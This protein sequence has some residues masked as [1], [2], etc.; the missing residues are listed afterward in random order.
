MR[1]IIVL[2]CCSC[3]VIMAAAQNVQTATNGLFHTPTTGTAVRTV[4]LGGT[5]T[6]ATTIDLGTTFTFGLKTTAL[7]NLF[8]VLNNGSIGIGI[9]PTSLFHIKAGTATLAP[10][11][12]TSGVSLATA[13]AGAMEYDGTSLFFTPSTIRKTI[14]FNDFSNIAAGSTLTAT[15]GGTGQTTLATGDLLYA[16]AANIFA[17]RTI[18][19]TGQVL[20]VV[21]GIPTWATPAAGGITSVFGRTG[22]VV[23]A[24]ND[25]T[26]AQIGAKPTT[27]AGY[28]ITDAAALSHT[29]TTGS[30]NT[31]IGTGAGIANTTGVQNNFIGANAGNVNTTGNYNSFLG[32]SAGSLNTIGG[33]NSF[34]GAYAGR[35]N[36]IGSDNC[37]LGYFAGQANQ[38]GVYNNFIGSQSGNATT[39]GS[40]NSFI[41]FQAGVTNTIGSD[42]NFIGKY[43]G[44]AN[45]S[46]NNN[47]A[48]GSSALHDVTTSNNNTAVGTN[49]GG[50]ITTGGNNTIIGANVLGLPA[51]LSNNIILADG[52]GNRRIN[53]D[54]NGNVG[55]GTTSPTKLLEVVGN[56]DPTIIVKTTGTSI[57]Q[58]LV[59][60]GS[61]NFGLQYYPTGNCCWPAG[62]TALTTG[63]SVGNLVF[64]T[65]NPIQFHINNQERA[66]FS[67]TG[68][69]GLGTSTPTEKL[70]VAGNIYTNGKIL[71]NQANTAAVAPYSLAVN[72]SVIFT[73]A[74]VKA[75]TNWP[76]YVFKPNYQLTPLSE[77]ETYLLQHHTYPMY[78]RLTKW[79]KMVLIWVVTK[80]CYCKR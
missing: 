75:N 68:N 30:N 1:K 32:F 19:T 43:A 8:T 41:G 21:G 51:A 27:L 65:L 22:L 78:L 57:A 69:L 28:G 10:L 49:T 59:G 7:P 16:S 54:A 34:A 37:F 66:R 9:S 39:S 29:H 48:I 71:I 77:L 72:G 3:T 64:Q 36:T 17:K 35:S 23:A 33:S 53:V 63:S 47:T 38:T 18:G 76:D 56:S 12:F 6:Q 61:N 20:T 13:S 50:G 79:K 25:Y 67:V 52:Q 58:V 14:S 2:L 62:T 15:N 11:K 42:N 70:D 31:A 44:Y 46:G 45:L 74:I 5:L 26:F 24:A 55:I 4:G 73:K 80:Q 60:D 40:A